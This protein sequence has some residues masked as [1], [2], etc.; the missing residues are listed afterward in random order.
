MSGGRSLE[1]IENAPLALCDP[2][3]VEAEDLLEV[4]QVTE[5][6]VGEI[7][8]VKHSPNQRWYWLRHKGR[9]RSV[10]S[11]PLTPIRVLLP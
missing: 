10:S 1:K 9:P 8:Y 2:N 6:C 5:R 4:D 11:L 3:T 7:Y